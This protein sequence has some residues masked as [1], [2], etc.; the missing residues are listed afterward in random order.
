M[1]VLGFDACAEDCGVVGVDEE[2]EP[3]VVKKLTELV[4]LC[5]FKSFRLK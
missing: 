3:G 4:T 5:V 1:P 2:F